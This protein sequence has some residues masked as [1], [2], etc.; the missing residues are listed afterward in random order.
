MLT[1][2]PIGTVDRIM[3]AVT[4]LILAIC[5]K[6]HDNRVAI[7]AILAGLLIHALNQNVLNQPA[8]YVIVDIVTGV[9]VVLSTRGD[10]RIAHATCWTAIAALHALIMGGAISGF[11]G[12]TLIKVLA[13][14]STI[15]CIP[16]GGGSRVRIHHGKFAGGAR[17]RVYYG[18]PGHLARGVFDKIR[19]LA[20]SV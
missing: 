15:Y 18:V 2:I 4:A 10:D 16:D 1:A 9:I 5:L 17:F 14:L 8:L 11:T 13:L 6:R 7:S 3:L 19:H 20:K 12:G